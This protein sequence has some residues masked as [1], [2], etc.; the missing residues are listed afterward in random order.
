MLDCS[1]LS[2]R[3]REKSNK[4]I[5]YYHSI[6]KYLFSQLRHNFTPR[7]SCNV[8]CCGALDIAQCV[9]ADQKLMMSRRKEK[10]ARICIENF[11]VVFPIYLSLLLFINEAIRTDKKNTKT[12]WIKKGP[13]WEDENMCKV[14]KHKIIIIFV[15]NMWIYLL[16]ECGIGS[17]LHTTE[18]ILSCIVVLFSSSSL[19]HSFFFFFLLLSESNESGGF[20]WSRRAHIADKMWEFLVHGTAS[21]SFQC[22]WCEMVSLK[23]DEIPFQINKWIIIVIQMNCEKYQFSIVFSAK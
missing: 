13:E 9:F 10:N 14:V 8:R 20:I 22:F 21:F 6:N 4:C 11:L 3:R 7:S 2:R 12:Q 23:L 1:S 18:L 5:Q 19:A 15:M 16:V 17:T